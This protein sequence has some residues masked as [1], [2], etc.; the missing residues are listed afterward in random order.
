[1]NTITKTIISF[2]II[3]SF[4]IT[5]LPLDSESEFINKYSK[6][7]EYYKRWENFNPQEDF[8]EDARIE[9]Y[10][11]QYKKKTLPSNVKVE[12]NDER[13]IPF[14]AGFLKAQKSDLKELYDTLR[15]IDRYMMG[16]EYERYELYFRFW[17]SIPAIDYYLNIYHAGLY[18]DRK[19]L[20]LDV[21]CSIRYN[22]SLAP[23]HFPTE[24][25]YLDKK[26]KP[27]IEDVIS[28]YTDYSYKVLQTYYRF[29]NPEKAIE[30][31]CR[32]ALNSR[33]AFTR[34][35][36]SL[37]SIKKKMR[38][39]I[40]PLDLKEPLIKVMQSK[41]RN[42]EFTQYDII[43]YLSLIGE[44]KNNVELVF[45]IIDNEWFTYGHSPEPYLK[46]LLKIKS[47]R[48]RN[49]LQN[50]FSDPLFKDTR[51]QIEGYLKNY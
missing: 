37:P 42:N 18:E 8:I 36:T 33:I 32:S 13:E 43:L 5:I 35:G 39:L 46:F 15:E 16:E 34:W 49:Y 30:L 19:G 2:F 26:L 7:K 12:F 25:K 41:Y 38:V 28:N 50:K 27:I 17:A 4:S 6:Y 22:M 11:K 40:F 20:A 45:K 10:L 3:L 24:I 21:L 31:A 51:A 9:D 1:M 29:Y 44:L 48:V 14:L 47:L 23:K